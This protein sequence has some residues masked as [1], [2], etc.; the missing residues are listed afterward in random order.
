MKKTCKKDS[1]CGFFGGKTLLALLLFVFQFGNCGRNGYGC[2]DIGYHGCGNNSIIDNSILFIIA[3]Y[4][5]CC[6]TDNDKCGK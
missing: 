4:F 1:N 5:I 3:L 2:G 6:C